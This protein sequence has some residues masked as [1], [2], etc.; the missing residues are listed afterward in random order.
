M[1]IF[2]FIV[3]LLIIAMSF[4]YPNIKISVSL[5]A[6][7]AEE[8]F[9]VMFFFPIVCVV[10]RKRDGRKLKINSLW[11]IGGLF[12]TAIGSGAVRF[13]SILII[14]GTDALNPKGGLGIFFFIVLPILVAISVCSLLQTKAHPAIEIDTI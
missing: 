10:I 12:L 9:S 6:F 4:I 1:P 3:I 11:L 13:V 7:V 2:S 8:F 5:T 14:G